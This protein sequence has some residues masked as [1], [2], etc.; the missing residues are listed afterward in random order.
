MKRGGWA[1]ALAAVLYGIPLFAC[2]S[3]AADAND[4][5]GGGNPDPSGNQPP[6]LVASDAGNPDSGDLV[7]ITTMSCTD[8]GSGAATR[9]GKCS[10]GEYHIQ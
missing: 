3:D 6:Q 8:A 7:K 9:R 4:D 5:R 2:S 10:D 1:R